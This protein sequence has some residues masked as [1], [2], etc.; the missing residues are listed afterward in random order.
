MRYCQDYGG[1]LAHD[2]KRWQRDR[3]RE[4]EALAKETTCEIYSEAAKIEDKDECKKLAK[5]AMQSESRTHLKQ[6]CSA[7]APSRAF[8]QHP[9]ASTPITGY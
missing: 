6:C 9:T 2:V 3:K 1:F 7:L 4:A 5:W 8:Q